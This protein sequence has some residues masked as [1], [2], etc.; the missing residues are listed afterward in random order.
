M[1]LNFHLLVSL[2]GFVGLVG[3]A[4]AAGLDVVVEA[5]PASG[6]LLG[7]RALLAGPSVARIPV[8]TFL[9]VTDQLAEIFHVLDVFGVYSRPAPFTPVYVVPTIYYTETFH[10]LFLIEI[11]KEITRDILRVGLTVPLILHEKEKRLTK[12][13]LETMQVSIH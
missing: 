1:F 4:A 8:V 9:P 6:A 7:G 10:K 11:V 12:K 13:R 3:V 5:A 2:D